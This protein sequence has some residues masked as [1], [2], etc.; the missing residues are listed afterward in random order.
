MARNLNP[1]QRKMVVHMVSSKARLTTSQVAKLAKSSVRLINK[2]R[3]N[4]RLSGRPNPPTI[5]PGPPP[6]INSVMLDALCDQRAE[7]PDLYRR[8]GCRPMGRVE[9]ITVRSS[10]QRALSQASE[11]KKKTQLRR[12]PES[13]AR[14]LSCALIARIIHPYEGRS[15]CSVEVVG[16][17]RIRSEKN[18]WDIR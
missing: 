1:W 6:S 7:T 18:K 9:H 3:K 14:R 15:K 17:E 13:R 4:M 16:K 10:I 11:M 5:P 8:D 2:I 12:N